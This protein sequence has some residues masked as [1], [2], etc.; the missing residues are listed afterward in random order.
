MNTPIAIV[1]LTRDEPDF[2]QQTVQ[3]IIERTHY[4]Y[5]LFIVDN[6]STS[7]TQL[8]MLQQYDD[9]SSIHVLFNQSN[10]WVLGFNQAIKVIR[11]RSNLSSKYMVLT[12]GDIVVPE[13]IDQL[14][15]LG[16]LKQKMDQN[17][18]IGKLGLALDIHSIRDSKDFQK[19]YQREYGYMQGP[20][21]DGLVVAPVDTT[22]AMYRF[23]LFVLPS[24][25]ML[26]GHASLV[27]P[28]YY[29]CR[30]QKYQAIHLGWQNYI[31]PKK[32]QLKDKVVCFTKYAGY[33]DPLVLG[34]TDVRTRFFYRF[35]RYFFIAY[36]AGLVAW[37]W[38]LYIVPRFP[39]NLNDIQSKLR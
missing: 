31:E 7:N 39:R 3:S 1:V 27:K 14:C 10:Q 34:K 15:W 35:F 36:W 2:L 13:A 16:H 19:T 33:I 5:E 24:F 25:K 26:P 22:L 9:N 8:N 37:Y 30:T 23:D 29:V 12:D 4:P 32:A 17:I 18:V 21:L 38:L 28:H 11:S 20:L 6:H